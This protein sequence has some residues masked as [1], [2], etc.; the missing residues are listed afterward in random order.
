MVSLEKLPHGFLR[1]VDVKTDISGL[2]T[3]AT[4]GLRA[5]RPHVRS[6]LNA[7]RDRSGGGA[8]LSG[9]RRCAAVSAC[10]ILTESIITTLD[11]TNLLSDTARLWARL[12]RVDL[13]AV[14]VR[15]GARLL[16][17]RLGVRTGT[18]VNLVDGGIEAVHGLE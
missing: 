16:R 1:Y 6:P 8:R 18:R 9:R 4:N 5:G 13:P 7:V 12:P 3:V 11:G 2:N 10:C 17:W 15:E 14:A